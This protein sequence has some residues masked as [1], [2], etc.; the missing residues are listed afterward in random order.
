V[1]FTDEEARRMTEE[2]IATYRRADAPDPANKADAAAKEVPVA[3]TQTVTAG[4]S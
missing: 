1:Q 4:K 2:F 3:A